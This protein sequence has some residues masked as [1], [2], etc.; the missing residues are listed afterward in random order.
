[1]R[2]R[3]GARRASRHPV[4][5]GVFLNW[6]GGPKSEGGGGCPHLAQRV[7]GELAVVP[8]VGDHL[9]VPV[10]V[11]TRARTALIAAGWASPRR[12]KP[13]IEAASPRKP[14]R[15]LA[16]Q[17]MRFHEQLHDGRVRAPDQREVQ[18]RVPVPVLDAAPVP[19]ITSNLATLGSHWWQ[20]A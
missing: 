7:V 12:A 6:R 11:G 10:R 4:R 9:L 16:R 3:R 19:V 14:L 5:A 17:R 20:H 15:S 2:R 1:M 8:V 13:M 18:W